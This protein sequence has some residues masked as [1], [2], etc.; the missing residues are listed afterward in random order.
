MSVRTVLRRAC[1]PFYVTVI[2]AC[3]LIAGGF[4]IL[5]LSWRGVARLMLVP[6]QLPFLVS[7]GV[8]GVALIGIG[9]AILGIQL[10]RYQRAKE[11]REIEDLLM[12]ATDLLTLA[13]RPKR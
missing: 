7:G 6:L 12:A 8:G 13:R 5:A 4:A 9:A 10:A 2:I 3:G 11:R 1:E